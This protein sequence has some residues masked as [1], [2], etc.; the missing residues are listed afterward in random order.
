MK[1]MSI[2]HTTVFLGAFV[3]ATV[4]V[5]AYVNAKDITYKA[6][7]DV[8]SGPSSNPKVAKGIVF[9]DKN[10]DGKRQSSEPGIAGVMV[11]NG[12]DVVVTDDRGHY[13]VPNLV[14][15]G[16]K[17][18]S[19]PVFVTKP[20]G[21]E[22]P[23]D[24][25]NI[26]Q[27]AYIHIPEGTPLNMRGEPFRFGGLKPSGPMPDRINFP[28]LKG[29]DK[30]NFTMVFSGDTQT[31]SNA[32][33]GYMRDSLVK[34][35]AAMSHLEAVVVEGDV[36]GDDLGLYGRYKEVMSASGAPLYLVAGNH[37]M[38]FDAATDEH[39]LDT[40]QREWGPANYSFDIGDVHFI[41]LDNLD[42][43]CKAEANADGLH[44]GCDDDILGGATYNGR[45]T[46]EQLQ[47]IKNDLSFVPKHKL[48]VVN[49]HIPILSFL[50]QNN[51]QGSQLDNPGAYFEALGCHPADDGTYP[52]HNCA[53]RVLALYGH[54]HTPSQ[55]RPGETFEG[56][57]TLLGVP[58]SPF[59]QIDT[60]ASAGSWWDGDFED[61]GTPRSWGRMGAPKGYYIFEF[62]GNY[63]VDT[64]KASGKSI[65]RQMSLSILS[66]TFM[67][68][69]NQL[70]TWWTADPAPGNDEL[71]PVSR[72]DL[73]D[74]KIVT[75]AELGETKLRANV[76]NGSIDSVVTVSIDGGEPLMMTRTQPGTGENIL[77]SIDPY[78]LVQTLQTARYAFQS[79]SGNERNQG[80]EQFRGSLRGPASPRPSTFSTA[81]HALWTVDLPTDLSIGVHVAKVTTID[82]HGREFSDAL[83]FEVREQR[84]PARFRSELFEV[85]P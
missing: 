38:D 31:Y 81:A 41:V 50:G 33:I 71:P 79:T 36:V 5:P 46:E 12:R 69:Y 13:E 77:E 39:S 37:D 34:E 72:M 20:A 75:T 74:T 52:A 24:K 4:I 80:Y 15:F 30:K 1:V 9:E 66:P 43:P 82:L 57:A 23:V 47:W 29:E 44:P 45:V 84:P 22:V 63:Y 17:K 16:P 2:V 70:I 60:G 3:T 78:Q 7:I 76:W 40:F 64:F 55:V 59:P 26:P 54:I 58:S 48:V 10:R 61:D 42:Y 14:D 68:W 35:L 11:S 8:R 49:Q 67:D 6:T 73:D 83:V 53:R 18:A 19:M 85:T 62:Y 51:I 32:E 56:W 65:E 25:D 27:F 28:L 21:Y